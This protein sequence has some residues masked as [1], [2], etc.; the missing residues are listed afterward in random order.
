MYELYAQ[1]GTSYGDILRYFQ[2]H[3]FTRAG[4]PWTRA[5][6]ADH[7]KNPVYVR[8]DFEV[9]EFFRS[10]ET[11]IES[12]VADFFGVNGCYYYKG[13]DT[14]TR[15]SAD[16]KNQ[17]LVLAPHEGI[18]PAALW[19]KCRKKCLSN[20]QIQTGRKATNTWL[21]GLVKCGRCGY[22]LTVKK[23]STRARYLLCSHK[24]NSGLCEGAGTIYADEFENLIFREIMKKLDGFPMLAAPRVP[25]KESGKR[26]AARMEL[27]KISQE[28]D[29]LAEKVALANDALMK[30]INERI[31]TLSVQKQQ[32]EQSL[33]E[34]AGNR[35]SSEKG[36]PASDY[37]DCWEKMNLNDKR[38]VADSLIE[39]I[40]AAGEKV[41]IK[42]KI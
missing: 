8:A 25:E 16:L 5:R 21:A 40:F 17:R 41:E 18:V 12:D 20:K 37:A 29:H 2:E 42:W 15:K 13:K 30:L 24:M 4:K 6:I 32:L 31:D 27:G 7:L 34:L 35:S 11:A 10:H 23:Y 1:P 19:L 38:A 9:Y 36:I 26:T 28:I 39:V 22:A 14:Q 33:A 3:N